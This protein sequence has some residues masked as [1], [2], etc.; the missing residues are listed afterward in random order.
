MSDEI[1]IRCYQCSKLLFKGRVIEVQVK[2]PR[3][4]FMNEVS[5]VERQK[6]GYYGSKG[7]SRIKPPQSD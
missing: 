6:G 7:F 1:C 4:G 5:A 2:C 3:C